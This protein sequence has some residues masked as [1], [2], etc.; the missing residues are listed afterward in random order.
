MTGRELPL[1]N[2][3]AAHCWANQQWQP[4]RNAL[5]KR[6][7]NGLLAREVDYSLLGGAGERR[8]GADFSWLSAGAGI[9]MGIEMQGWI[10]QASRQ[11]EAKDLRFHPPGQVGPMG[12]AVA[13]AGRPTLYTR[14]FSYRTSR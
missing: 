9:R 5:T 1:T 3:A 12:A 4:A 6:N 13:A 7:C 11:F 14:P 10:R 8:R 2:N